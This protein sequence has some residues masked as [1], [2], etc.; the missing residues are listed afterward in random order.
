MWT[1]EMHIKTKKK[2]KDEIYKQ[3]GC[4]M[5]YM[6]ED[7]CIHGKEVESALKQLFQHLRDKVIFCRFPSF[8]CIPYNWCYMY[9]VI[10][11]WF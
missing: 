2:H 1:R 7:S 9:K 5:I 10:L 4:I 6:I 8:L 3:S 11:T